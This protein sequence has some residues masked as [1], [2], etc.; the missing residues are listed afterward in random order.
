LDVQLM[1]QAG[2]PVQV[3]TAPPD[4]DGLRGLVR[5]TARFGKPVVA[6]IE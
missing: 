1:D 2:E 6:A 4:A 3:C 5:Q